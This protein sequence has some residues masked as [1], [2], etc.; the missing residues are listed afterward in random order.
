MDSFTQAY[1]D[2]ALWSSVAGENGEIRLDEHDGEISDETLAEI[3]KECIDFQ[4]DNAAW[5]TKWYEL[6][7]IEERAG[8]DFWLTRNR[9]GAGFWDHYNAGHKGYAIGVILSDKAHQCGG[10]ELY[11]G[12]DNLIRQT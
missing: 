5:L 7:E 6:G 9:H 4:A 10:R 3:E 8:H 11:I 1:I 2:C 12:D